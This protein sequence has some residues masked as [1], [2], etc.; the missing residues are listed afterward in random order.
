MVNYYYLFK[1]LQRLFQSPIPYL[2]IGVGLAAVGAET[3][4]RSFLR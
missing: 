1:R 3:V 2:I 4:A